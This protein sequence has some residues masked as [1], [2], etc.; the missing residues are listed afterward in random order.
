[1]CICQTLTASYMLWFLDEPEPMLIYC[2]TSKFLTVTKKLR[3]NVRHDVLRSFLS[4]S[5]TQDGH[6]V[7]RNRDDLGWVKSDY[8]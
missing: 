6:R 3:K 5:V 7:E 1:M 2:G 4:L 8:Q